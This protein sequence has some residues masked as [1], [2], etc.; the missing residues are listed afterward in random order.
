MS[1]RSTRAAVSAST[2][3]D[4]SSSI[5]A[6]LNQNLPG[7]SHATERDL[8]W[9]VRGARC[10]L[11]VGLCLFVTGMVNAQTP[12]PS[13]VDAPQPGVRPALGPFPRFED[14]S[15]LRDP[16][17][18]IDP[19]DR[20]KFI[21]LNDSGTNYLTLG[22]E[23]RTEFQYLK[24]NAWGAGPQ[25]LTGYVFER[26][27][28]SADLHLGDHAR[29]FVT[30]AFDDVGAKK[31]G[32]RPVIDKDVADGHEGFVEF[33]GNLHDR[34]PGWDVI[35]GRQEVS[36]GT[37]RLLDNNEGV[38]VRSAFDGIRLGYDK[39]KG[40]IDLI[41]VKPVE[42]NPGAWDDIP[43]PAITLW[44]LYASN[45]RWNSQFMSDVYFL[46][47][48]AASAT[49]QNQSAREQRRTIGARYFNRPP[50]EPPTAGFDYNVETGF[51]W[52]SFGNRSI[53]AWGAGA[54]IGWTLPSP[55]WRAHFGF[56]A[57]ALSGDNGRPATLG[58][59]NAM[60]PRG[61]YFGPKF[62]FIGPAN[63][64]DLQP[65]VVFHPLQNVTGTFEWIWFW[66]ES[67]KDA[68]YTFGN[69]PLRPANLSSARYVGSQPNLEIRWAISEHFLAALN[70]AGFI[71]G[72]FLQQSPP[73]KEIVFFN[74]GLT[75]RF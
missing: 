40:R 50:N 43:N 65:Q 47:Y 22:V 37:G 75:Y 8:I 16:S 10:L 53:R 31:A 64:L 9:V 33:G 20:L 38:N 2:H 74:A 63:L 11:I 54:N 70:V 34:H 66:R 44:G 5:R 57:D 72:T 1:F 29:I 48:D 23:N 68:L 73:S 46:D 28:P 13:P 52:G 67:P 49:Y 69:V 19:Y 55:V 27:M 14:W 36:L 17:Q 21:P 59:L 58:T 3:S 15:F 42:T 4:R 12:D 26:L 56:Q 30:L 18:R 45:V 24:N 61:A 32:P 6:S 71:T 41:A 62:A 39:P 7:E 35:I 25:D 51:Q 60:F